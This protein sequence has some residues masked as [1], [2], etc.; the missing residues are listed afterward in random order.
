MSSDWVSVL[1]CTLL[2]RFRK[3]PRTFAAR[4]NTGGTAQHDS[5]LWH[6]ENIDGDMLYSVF[7]WEPSEVPLGD[8][9]AHIHS[10]AMLMQPT[11][12]A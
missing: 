12:K 6:R 10:R 8:A 5:A 2:G 9:P 11:F 1:G 7:F 4:L 3:V